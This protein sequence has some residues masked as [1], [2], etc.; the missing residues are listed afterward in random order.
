LKQNFMYTASRFRIL[1]VKPIHEEIL[2]SLF[3]LL[4]PE[5]VF[6]HF[7]A[8]NSSFIQWYQVVPR[9]INCN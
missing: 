4:T 1:V 3:R 8:T 5:A 2:I 9:P 7:F 6:I